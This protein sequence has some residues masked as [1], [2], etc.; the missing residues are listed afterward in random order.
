MAIPT[1]EPGLVVHF[2]Y[3]WAR[4]HGEGREE[5]RYARPCAVILSYRRAAD[6]SLIVL[7]APITHSQPRDGDAAIEIP[8]KVKQHLGLDGERSWIVVDEVNETGWP[9][10]DLQ[11]NAK[12]E[13]AYGFL[14]PK[15]Y[16]AVKDKIVEAL[17]ARSLKRAPR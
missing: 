10:Y 2:N 17:Q 16:N 6:G 11:P 12:G 15:L 7:L 5:A 4:E 8:L 1:P 3:L 9:G 13:Y 14:P